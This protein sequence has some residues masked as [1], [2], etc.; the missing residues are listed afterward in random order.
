MIGCLRMPAARWRRTERIGITRTA[1]RRTCHAGR[2]A[3]RDA[4]LRHAWR[5]GRYLGH[6]IR[7]DAGATN[8]AEDQVRAFLRENLA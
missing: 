5:G 2:P 6:L 4:Q 7:P 8:A 1:G 3:G